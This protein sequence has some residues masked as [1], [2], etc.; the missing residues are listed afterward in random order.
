M[1]RKI[2][3]SLIMVAVLILVFIPALAA[4]QKTAPTAVPEP[5]V[6]EVHVVASDWE[7]VPAEIVVEKNTLIKFYVT[8]WHGEVHD[9]DQEKEEG[10][11]GHQHE[12]EAHHAPGGYI[13]SLAIPGYH[14]DLKLK[15]GENYGELYVDKVGEFSFSC[16]V[17]CGVSEDGTEGHHTMLGKLVVVEP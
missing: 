10:H 14:F 4:C 6:Q 13:H 17:W 15:E 11:E 5:K 8:S 9:G 3:L 7:F 2:R 16:Q 1:E 12:E